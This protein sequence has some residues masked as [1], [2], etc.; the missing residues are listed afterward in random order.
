MHMSSSDAG[1][2]RAAAAG[3]VAYLVSVAAVVFVEFAI[4]QKLF[5]AGQPAETARNILAHEGRFHFGVALEL[6]FCV[7]TVIAAGCYYAVLER[8]GRATA[9]VSALTRLF[10]AGAWF[11]ASMR[12]ADALRMIKG[13]SYLA[14]ISPEQ[15]QALAQLRL[16]GRGNDYYIGLPFWAVS[17]TLFAYLWYRSRYIPRP[18][19]IAGIVASAWAIVCA[20]AYL[21]AP[22]FSD[23]VNLWWF[24]SPM[25]LFELGLAVW[26][27]FKGL[28]AAS[29]PHQ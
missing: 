2:R 29:G 11:L 5:Y 20:F 14:A 26:I 4:Y 8:F 25:V 9:I 18:F 28:A 3:A 17:A 10:Y 7:A 19:A 6:V 12:L 23:V 15:L 24:D 16:N 21:A 13:G 1:V 22:G 27:L